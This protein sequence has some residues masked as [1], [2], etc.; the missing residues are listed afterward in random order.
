[1]AF[2]LYRS[3]RTETLAEA[4]SGVAQEPL[5]GVFARE[6]IVVQGPGMERWLSSVLATRLGIWANPWFPFPRAAVEMVLDAALGEAKQVSASFAPDALV[7]RLARALPGRLDE[8]RFAEVA[9][10]LRD[11]RDH[12]RLLALSQKLASTFDQYLVYRPELVLSWEDGAGEH[13]QAELWRELAADRPAH[14]ARRMQAYAERGSR[15]LRLDSLPARISLFGLSTL[16]PAFLHVLKLA[17]ERIDLHM[18]AL[19]PVRGY[20]GDLDRTQRHQNDTQ[21]LVADL[22]KSCRD[23]FELLLESGA[24]DDAVDAFVAPD[25]EHL[26]AGLQADLMELVERGPGGLAPRALAADD[27]SLRISSCHSRVRELEVLRDELRHRFE[28]D[29][30]LLP[31]EIVVFA[32]D[33][34]LYAPAIEAV[35]APTGEDDK[36]AIPFRV[37][38]RKTQRASE[39]SST[40]FA[41][42]DLLGSR[43]ALSDVLDFL[44]RPLV[45]A[46]FGIEESE[47]DRVQHW[48]VRAGARW[49]IDAEHRA[50]F[51]QPGFFENSLRFAVDRLLLG[52]A[53]AP[54]EREAPLSLMPFDA[55]EGQ[56]AELLGRVARYFTRLADLAR[57]S[58]EARSIPAF[59]ELFSRALLLLDDSG[60]SSLEH[61]VLRSTLS[62][63]AAQ[64]VEA[65]F[66]RS[67]SREAVRALLEERLERT[68]LNA[69]FLAGGVTFCE[70]VP[71]RAIPFRVVCLLG[72]DDEAFPRG[73][74]RHSFDLIAETPRRGDRNLRDDDRQLFLEA[75]LSARDALLISYVGRSAQDD[76]ARPVSALVEHLLRVIDRLFVP[77]GR[78]NNL[79]LALE[80]SVSQQLLREH[81]LHRFDRRY[82][83]AQGK[84][85]FFSYDARALEAARAEAAWAG[86]QP[87]ARAGER[88]RAPFVKRPLPTLETESTLSLESLINYFRNPQRSFLKQRL[89]VH[90]PRELDPI[91][92]R[93]PTNLD[94]LER[95]QIGSELLTQLAELDA[96]ERARVLK[97]AGRLPPGT[98]GEVQLANIEALVA[99]VLR[100]GEAG[101]A[102]PDHSFEIALNEGKLVGRLDG[103]HTR[104]RVERTVST[105]R[106]KHKLNA[107]LRHLA[108]CASRSEPGRTLL[109]GR[110]NDEAELIEFL[111]VSDARALLEDLVGLYRL[112]MHMPL[113]YL[114]TP[115]QTLVDRL[116]KGEEL[117]SALRAASLVAL[118]ASSAAGQDRDGDDPHVRQVFSL[119]QL[120]DLGSLCASDGVVEVAFA[121][122]ARRI[123]EPLQRHVGARSGS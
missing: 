51:G 32:P 109:I 114:H 104:A 24:D 5:S 8:P 21:G 28:R 64:A 102:M 121:D 103:M 61:H 57:E 12:V 110:R 17:S 1:V 47:L 62:T 98:L 40:F 31:G 29:A 83:R 49:A 55:V 81:A 38:D 95:Y 101:E 22:G 115:A 39:V 42:L 59:S 74:P 97:Q 108:L 7:F 111:P 96:S 84:G 112:G 123:L 79:R 120:E 85:P 30:T 26:L 78:D 91:E 73:A 54:G 92:G 36:S 9:R 11:D 63:L 66:E 53:S 89:S 6:C 37:A 68:R 16:P 48:L 105:L 88:E 69:G 14:L 122:V 80:G 77:S 41:L 71:M 90:L 43:L 50:S 70:H 56:E 2:R 117:T 13:F 99:D 65:G 86:F 44:H 87:E 52:Y 27:D 106:T 46:R 58:V 25:G 33:I 116:R 60:V 10:Y 75:L 34:E 67:V 3:N 72:M 82:F 45:R 4:L 23:L 119:R 76:S 113:P 100:T 35:F 19:S 93:E 94:A 107:W 20:F 118:P 15:V 18:F